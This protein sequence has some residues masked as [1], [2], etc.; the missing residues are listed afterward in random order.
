MFHLPA[1]RSSAVWK[2]RRRI[3]SALVLGASAMMT[4]VAAVDG[5][6]GDTNRFVPFIPNGTFFPNPGGASQTYSTI[7]RGIERRETGAGE[8]LFQ[9]PTRQS[10]VM[11]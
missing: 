6:D 1:K 4:V 11:K 5:Q 9:H 3:L 2:F 10:D 8:H 7:G